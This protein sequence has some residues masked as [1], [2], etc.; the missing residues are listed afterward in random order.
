[1]HEDIS[2]GI[3]TTVSTTQLHLL[4]GLL[5]KRGAPNEIRHL[6]SKIVLSQ[7]RNVFWESRIL[8]VRIKMKLKE[9]KGLK[10][11]WT[12]ASVRI[13]K[14]LQGDQ[15][16]RYEDI[17]KQELSRVWN[18]EKAKSRGKVSWFTR[19]PL[20]ESIQGI[21]NRDDELI[22]VFGDIPDEGLVLGGIEATTEIK[23]FLRLDPKFKVFKKLD[24]HTH[25]TE[26]E[27][28]AFKQRISRQEDRGQAVA[29]EQRLDFRAEAQRAKD[30]YKL[31]IVDFSCYK[32]GDTGLI[33][34]IS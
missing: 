20:L 23:A 26:A 28:T 2:L 25:E 12:R 34:T 33:K 13:R 21:P 3:K 4:K 9:I 27:T 1:M 15:V 18:E 8:L 7:S 5:H 11:M 10:Y 19:S 24:S 17:K 31:G 32:S 29:Q 16:Q 30:P 14:I 6:A 22:R